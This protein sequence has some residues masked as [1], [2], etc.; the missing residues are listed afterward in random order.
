MLD[1]EISKYVDVLQ[2]VAQGCTMPP[3]LFKICINDLIV[4][5]EPARQ[6]VPVGEDA[7]SGLMFEDD[8]VGISETPERLQKQIEKA[9]LRGTIV[10]RTYG[11]HKSVH[12]QTFLLTIFGPINFGPP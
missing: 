5:V 10:N 7:V 6:G 9:L 8:F 3:N 4:A 1:G 12:I 11:I 2:G